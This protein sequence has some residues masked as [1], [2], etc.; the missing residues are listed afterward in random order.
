MHVKLL[1]L[2]LSLSLSHTHTHTHTLMQRH[3]IIKDHN[4]FSY[5]RICNTLNESSNF[6]TESLYIWSSVYCMS[7]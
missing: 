7:A 1:S 4:Y 3:K 5:L 6:V 2:S